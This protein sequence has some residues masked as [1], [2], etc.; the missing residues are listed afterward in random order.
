MLDTSEVERQ[1]DI[2]NEKECPGDIISLNAQKVH[3]KR[4]NTEDDGSGAELADANKVK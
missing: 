2:A 3:E 1:L 4:D